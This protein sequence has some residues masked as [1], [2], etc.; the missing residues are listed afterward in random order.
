MNTTKLAAIEKT[1]I[2]F[3]SEQVATLL[4]G[5]DVR[6]GYMVWR[7]TGHGWT[8]CL[9]DAHGGTPLGLD[10]ECGS[11]QE[12][13][14]LAEAELRKGLAQEKKWM[15]GYVAGAS[16]PFYSVGMGV[17]PPPGSSMARHFKQQAENAP[18]SDHEAHQRFVYS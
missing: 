9:M 4:A 2:A 11:Q 17:S 12:A 15:E 7:L 18:E 8:P 10:G 6:C 5:G 13:L 1:G 16:P 14:A 3:T